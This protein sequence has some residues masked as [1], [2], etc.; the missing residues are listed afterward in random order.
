MSSSNFK[1][2]RPY[3]E[4]EQLNNELKYT[5]P[6]DK[7]PTPNFKELSVKKCLVSMFPIITWLSEYNIK[8]DIAG[9][10]VSGCTVA[11]MHIPQGEFI[12]IFYSHI[13]ITVCLFSYAENMLLMLRFII[14]I[15][16]LCWKIK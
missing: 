7:F 16:Y 15:I 6:K 12:I 14:V 1:V 10:I 13:L 5:K 4:Q 3:Y 8:R 11:I 9:D 2:E